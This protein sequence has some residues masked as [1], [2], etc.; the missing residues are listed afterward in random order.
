MGFAPPDISSA[1]ELRVWKGTHLAPQKSERE[2][3]EVERY[4]VRLLCHP[5]T[6]DFSQPDR[7]S[8]FPYIQGLTTQSYVEQ[9]AKGIEKIGRLKQMT[10]YCRCGPLL[11]LQSKLWTS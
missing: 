11:L 2:G 1:A 6:L 5:V 9:H 8:T 10:V 4:C 3:S 7:G